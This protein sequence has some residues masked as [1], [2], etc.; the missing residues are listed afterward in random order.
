MVGYLREHDRLNLIR[1]YLAAVS[2]DAESIVE[3]LI[4]MDTA[5]E[6]VNRE[7][8]SREINRLLTKYQGLPLKDI[9]ANEIVEEIMPIAFHHHLSL[10]SDLWLLLKTLA[11]ME[12]V[13]LEL[14]PDFD[15]F[16]VA[17]PFMR[18]LAWQLMLPRRKWGQNILRQG[19]DWGEL[20]SALP[21]TGSRLLMRAERGDLFQVGLKDADR[22]M[23][24][25]DRL[26][27]RL[28]LSVLASS[29]IIGLAMLIPST[30]AGSLIQWMVVIGFSGAFGLGVW[31]LISII[32]AE[33]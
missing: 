3:Q 27:T 1:L 15:V 29:L 26:T 7:R 28:A 2:L 24:V 25:L 4:R 33:R 32:K 6:E 31:L 8:L 21:R 5:P 30:T 20:L 16:A 17:E 14:D 12:G 11:M 23:R 13:G 19:A 22:I 18:R 10:P 9:R